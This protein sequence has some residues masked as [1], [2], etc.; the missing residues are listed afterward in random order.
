MIILR[1]QG[2]AQKLDEEREIPTPGIKYNSSGQHKIAARESRKSSKTVFKAEAGIKEEEII[3][4]DNPQRNDNGISMLAATLAG[5]SNSI[6]EVQE[7]RQLRIR[8][9][10]EE[11]SIRGGRDSKE[12]AEAASYK[13]CFSSKIHRITYIPGCNGMKYVQKAL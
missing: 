12:G 9:R 11:R 13:F 2:G 10:P 5:C 3:N 4:E 7:V 1:K 8:H 6:P